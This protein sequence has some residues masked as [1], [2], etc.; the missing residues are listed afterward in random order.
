VFRALL[1]AEHR[2]AKVTGRQ[3]QSLNTDQQNITALRQQLA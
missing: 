3:G 2:G 1:Y